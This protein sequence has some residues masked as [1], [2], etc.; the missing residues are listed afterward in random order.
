MA[1]LTE[2]LDPCFHLALEEHL[3]DQVEALAPALYLWRSRS[4][5]VIGK[6]QNPWRECRTDLLVED[7]A[8]LARRV[9]GG[10][11][12]YHDQGNLNFTFLLRREAYDE[13]RQ[14]S[15]VRS[16][17]AA[18]GVRTDLVNRNSLAVDGYKV[19]GSA[20][21]FRRRA[22]L[23]HGT[24]LVN[25]D[26][27]RLHRYLSPAGS[28][29]RTHAIASVPASVTNLAHRRPDLDVPLV[30]TSL[31]AA[32]RAA[33]GSAA[34]LVDAGVARGPA[35]DE[36]LARY[37]SDAWRLARTPRFTVPI[38]LAPH[39][40]AA[41]LAIE[42]EQGH[43]RGLLVDEATLPSVQPCRDAVTGTAFDA[44][45]LAARLAPL[46]KE[47]SVA[48]ALRACLLDQAFRWV[49]MPQQ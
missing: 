1:M 35:F 14:F 44:R 43:V 22:A 2:N 30:A 24:L 29:Y 36:R 48:G 13:A 27:D 19:S 41:A 39:G 17:L 5:V 18:L 21:C 15:V 3:L 23:H 49:P 26:L 9:S 20:F 33:Y 38:D 32:F 46:A 6:H 40:W 16:A 11:A 45:A 12:V 8:C 28:G 25:A 4:G 31:Q 37:R 42:V 34:T 7:G 47:Q 10:G